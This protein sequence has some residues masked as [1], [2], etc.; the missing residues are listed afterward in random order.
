[1]TQQLVF[2]TQMQYQSSSLYVFFHL[3]DN[4]FLKFAQ[5]A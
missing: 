4:Y 5:S 3:L 1:M 2:A